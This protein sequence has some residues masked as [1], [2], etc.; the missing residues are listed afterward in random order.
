MRRLLIVLSPLLGA[1]AL[2]PAPCGPSVATAA[3]SVSVAPSLDLGGGSLA[4]PGP[5]GSVFAAP[6]ADPLAGACRD[7][8]QASTGG[9]TL[10]DEKGEALHGLDTPRMLRSPVHDQQPE[11]R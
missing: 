8:A 3:P 6:V 9:T 4:I 7:A 11:Y 2:P 10:R 5:S 1:A